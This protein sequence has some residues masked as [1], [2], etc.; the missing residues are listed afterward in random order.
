M[1]Q[2]IEGETENNNMVDLYA[3]MSKITLIAMIK[4]LQLERRNCHNY[5]LPIKMHFQHR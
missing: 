2:E 1:Y 3:T 5:M 4:A